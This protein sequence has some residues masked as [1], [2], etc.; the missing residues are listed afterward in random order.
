MEI[1]V[2]KIIFIVVI[3]FMALIAGIIPNKSN[4]CRNSAAVLGVANAFTGGIFLAIALLHILPEA[5]ETYADLKSSE[6]EH[7]HE[8][9]HGGDEEDKV[10]PL[11]FLLVFVGYALILTIDKVVFDSAGLLGSQ[12]DPVENK[13]IE[14]ARKSFGARGQSN[15]Q[16]E[17][18]HAH[19]AMS[20]NAVEKRELNSGI[21]EYLSRNDKFSVRMSVAMGR[22]SKRQTRSLLERKARGSIDIEAEQRGLFED[23]KNVHLNEKA[24]LAEQQQRFD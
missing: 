7:V 24:L 13:I 11:P 10:F 23:P 5:S 19:L 8:V 2:V 6:D 9:A 12:E 14:T 21:K 20:L 4:A 3:F 15:E 22:N 17:R 1:L 18:P 16:P